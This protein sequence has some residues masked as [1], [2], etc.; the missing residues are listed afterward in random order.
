MTDPNL[1]PAPWR[2]EDVRIPSFEDPV[3]IRILAADGRKVC[4]IHPDRSVNGGGLA[5]A[6]ADAELICKQ[7]MAI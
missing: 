2:A 6:R 1:S 4:D 3:C 7:R 5:R